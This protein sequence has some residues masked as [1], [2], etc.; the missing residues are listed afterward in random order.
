MKL[1]LHDQQNNNIIIKPADKNLGITILDK[2]WYENECYSNLNNKN[3]YCK[4]APVWIKLMIPNIIGQLKSSLYLLMNESKYL[5]DFL[6]TF[7]F[8][9]F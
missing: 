1:L 8:I 6:F 9:N 4:I 2:K 7:L 5:Y 3:N